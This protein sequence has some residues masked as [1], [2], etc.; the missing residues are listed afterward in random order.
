MKT[1]TRRLLLTGIAAT[2]W[3]GAVVGGL[4]LASAYE[5]RA[6]ISADAPRAWPPRTRIARREGRVTVLLFAHPLCPCTRA[7]VRELQRIAARGRERVDIT[8]VLAGAPAEP[9]ALGVDES[10]VRRLL[11]TA[12]V[13]V[14]EDEARTFSVR[15]SGQ[16]LAYDERGALAFA[17]GITPGRGHEGPSVG[18]DDLLRI[19]LGE[20]PSRGHARVFG[21]ALAGPRARSA[22]EH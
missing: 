10:V 17:G 14:G 7:S 1:A 11:P 8:V 19:A 18:G 22:Q 5:A 2:L 21:C 12:T 9:S 4:G 6:G 13:L 20:S 3:L 15:T 16:V